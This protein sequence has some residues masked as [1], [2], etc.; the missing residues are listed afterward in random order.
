[1][2]DPQDARP[3]ARSPFAAAF[4]SLLFPGLGHLY[5]GAPSRALAFAAAPV[6]LIALLAGIVLR[7]DRIE[8]V[9]LALNPFLLSSVFV[10]NLIALLYRLVAVIDAYRVAEFM[11]AVHASAW[12]EPPSRTCR[13]RRGTARSGSMSCSS[14]PISARRR[15]P[16]TPT[17]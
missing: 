16:T 8:L 14:G 10:A 13:S 1:M 17:P 2:H 15:A 7:L 6:L 5:A 12:S 9:G 11:N 3:R 4:L